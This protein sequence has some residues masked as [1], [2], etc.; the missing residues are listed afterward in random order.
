M[1]PP[2]A[3]GAGL[4]QIELVPTKPAKTGVFR[5]QGTDDGEMVKL[6]RLIVPPGRISGGAPFRGNP[7]GI[8]FTL[9]PGV[10]NGLMDG[11]S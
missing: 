9:A 6:C 2:I 8:V 4:L 5:A 11:F 1:T 10:I 7:V 3:Q